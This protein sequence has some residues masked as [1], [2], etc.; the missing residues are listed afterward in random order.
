M[1]EGEFLKVE[2]IFQKC[3]L[4]AWSV[5]LFN[6]YLDYIRRRNDVLTGGE[7][8]RTTI[9]KAYDFVISIVGIDKD[10]GPIWADYLDFVK[11]SQVFLLILFN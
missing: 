3:L 4:N 9:L 8:A 11:S 1:N 7:K 6:F 5:D 10:S 2:E